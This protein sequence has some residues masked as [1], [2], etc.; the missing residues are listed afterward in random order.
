MG[1]RSTA[2]GAPPSPLLCTFGLLR[3]ERRPPGEQAASH[4]ADCRPARAYTPLPEAVGRGRVRPP[5]ARR[6]TM[7]KMFLSAALALVASGCSAKRITVDPP[8]ERL[9]ESQTSI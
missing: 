2:P 6:W 1:A 9:A 7:R 5:H 8:T 4:E 3:G